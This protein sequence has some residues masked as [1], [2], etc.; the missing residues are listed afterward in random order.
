M[1]AD[2]LRRRD[3]GRVAQAVMPGPR[4]PILA[5]DE[6][7]PAPPR[8]TRSL[9]TRKKL[10]EAGRYLFAE[11]GYHATSI[12]DIAARAGTAAG[13]FYTYFHSKRQLLIVLMNELLDRLH[14]LDLRPKGGDTDM[15]AGLR[16]FLA[17]VFRADLEYYGVVRA[18]QEAALTDAA[19]GRMQTA[20]EAWTQAR[21]LRVFK[22]LQQHPNARTDC[23]LPAFA[24]MMDRHFWSILARGASLTRRD[25]DR[26]V[27]TAADVIY[28]YLFQDLGRAS[29][30]AAG[31]ESCPTI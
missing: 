29:T 7:P 2:L 6:D 13:A 8:Q 20:I 24:S 18:W 16:A 19:L 28:H 4:P 26:E 15:R 17:V 9:A 12:Q 30:P 22:A 25:F 1:D 5:D 27:R 10:L 31:V 11:R 14:G 3:R 23:D 21:I